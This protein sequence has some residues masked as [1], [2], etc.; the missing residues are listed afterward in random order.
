MS[1]DTIPEME[2]AGWGEGGMQMTRCEDLAF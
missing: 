1:G 2:G